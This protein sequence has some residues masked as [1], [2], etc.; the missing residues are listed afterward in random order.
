MPALDWTLIF[1][2]P[3]RAENMHKIFQ[4]IEKNNYSPKGA[5]HHGMPVS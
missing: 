5:S 2:P 1:A 3:K 4:K